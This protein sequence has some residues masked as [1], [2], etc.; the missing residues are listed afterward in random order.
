M[1][2]TQTPLDPARIRETLRGYADS[3]ETDPLTN[4]V[5]SFALGLFQD[6]DSGRTDLGRI[7]ETVDALHFDLL[8]ERA[9]QFSR[10]RAQWESFQSRL[11][12][13]GDRKRKMFDDILG[14]DAGKRGH[15]DAADEKS[16]GKKKRKRKRNR[17]GAGGAGTEPAAAKVQVESPRAA[18][19]D[20]DLG[21]A[22]AVKQTKAERKA[23][24]KGKKAK[25]AKKA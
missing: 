8:R 2:K 17:A 3:I 6:L 21:E 22:V 19:G 20:D 24:K 18:D 12:N 11:A 14:D 1:P 4:S 7:G 25:K 23:A 9:E 15:G 10:D 13:D 5:F 16:G